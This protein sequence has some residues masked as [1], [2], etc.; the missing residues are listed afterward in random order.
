[1]IEYIRGL[2]IADGSSIRMDCPE[3]RG[4][5]TFTVTN[6]NGQ[7]LWNCYKASCNVSGAHKMSMSAESIYRRLNMTEEN[8]IKWNI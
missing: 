2:D 3:C 7:L 6:N 1:M 5:K 8:K 4:R